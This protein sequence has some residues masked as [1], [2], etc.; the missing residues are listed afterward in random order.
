MRNISSQFT[1]LK[2]KLFDTYYSGLNDMQRKAVFTVKGPLLVLAGAGSGK[3]TVL[4]NRI[5]HIIRYGD[6]YYD[7]SVPENVSEDDLSQMEDALS[8]SHE[9]L[10]KYLERFA[11]DT[12]KPWSVMGITFTNKAANEIKVRIQNIFGEDGADTASQIKTGTFHSICVRILRRYCSEIGYDPGF[13]ICDSSDSQKMLLDCMK[14][15]DIDKKVLPVKSVQSE[16]SRAKDSMISPEE[17]SESAGSDYRVQLISRVYTLY[18][19]RLKK[20][21]L[22]DFDDLIYKT[23]ELMTEFPDIRERLNYT[24]RYICVDEFQDTSHAQLKLT[25]LLTGPEQNIMVVGDDDQSIYKFRGAVIDNILRF[26]THFKG[27]RIIK[28][29]ENYRSTSNILNAANGVISHNVNRH[30]K[31]LW[32]RKDPGDKITLSLLADQTEEARYISRVISDMVT[33]RT[34]AYK[35]FAVLYRMNA[36]SR[37]IEQA[38]TKSGIPYRLL[39]GLRFYDRK[40][41]KDVVSYLKVI[42]NP[43]DDL[44]LERII[45]EPRR[46]IGAKSIEVAKGIAA[47]EGFTLLECMRNAVSYKAISPSAARAMRE[48]AFLIDGLREYAS[49]ADS[50]DVIREVLDKSGYGKMISMIQDRTEREERDS[51]INELVSAATEYTDVT[52]DPSLWGFLEDVALVSDVDK[53]DEDADAVVL[54]TIHSAKGLEFPVVFLPGMEE[55]IFPSY[56]SSFKDDDIE[57]ERRLAYVAITRAKKKVIMSYVYDRMI[58]GQTQYNPVSRF[59]REIPE[60]YIEKTDSRRTSQSS[61][62][63]FSG[64]AYK[65]ATSSGKGFTG[66]FSGTSAGKTGFGGAMPAVQARPAVTTV[67]NTGDRVHH[68]TF[69]DGTILSSKNIGADVLYEIVFDNVGTKKLMATYARL[70]KADN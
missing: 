25:L 61:Y 2:R 70:K 66:P 62:G 32:T 30:G 60:E 29:E 5:S 6:A 45:N 14:D 63:S 64:S 3:T 69:G 51:N 18:Q 13:S 19:K 48:F 55:N 1:E 39:G 52:E 23:V 50:A 43:F 34:A 68:N 54:M 65:G 38:L 56:M 35:D 12:A 8:Y 11:K 40:E 53:Y 41:I 28:L 20:Q 44:S 21:N 49:S 58:N 37:N 9:E 4:V 22:F 24:Y 10:G 42:A 15:L 26:D 36:Q 57:E 7:G 31:S 17:Y 16:I 67:F 59:V 27:T 46:G 33:R 47:E